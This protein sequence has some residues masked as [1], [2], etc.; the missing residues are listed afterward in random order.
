MT[1]Y[2]TLPLLKKV[3]ESLLILHSPWLSQY[4]SYW[5]DTFHQYPSTSQTD[6]TQSTIIPVLVLLIWY[7]LPLPPDQVI[8]IRLSSLLSHFQSYL[9]DKVQFCPQD[10]FYWY[11]TVQ[12]CPIVSLTDTTQSTTLQVS[13]LLTSYS[14]PISQYQ[15]Y[16]YDTEYCSRTSPSNTTQ[17]TCPTTSSYDTLYTTTSLVPDLLI[18]QSTTARVQVILITYILP[19]YQSFWYL[20]VNNCPCT[21]S[22]ATAPVTI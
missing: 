9:Y 11:D 2:M 5:Y 4:R 21:S 14:P 20:T 19:L 6:T 18:G 12:N 7:N 15:S 1:Q 8:L 16:W 10:Q 22:I 13:I 17:S 3:R